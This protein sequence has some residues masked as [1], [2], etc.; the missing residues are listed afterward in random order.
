MNE[1]VTGRRYRHAWRSSCRPECGP[2]VGTQPR[3]LSPSSMGT[4]TSCP[5]A[6]RFSYIERL[7]EAAVGAR[8]QGHA[9][10]PGAAAPDV[11]AARRAHDRDRARRPR[12]GRAPSSR[13]TPSSRSS[14]S[15]TRSGPRSTP[16]PRCSCAATSRSRTRA[17]S[18]CSASSCA[19][20]AE[21]ADG[22]IDP[23]HH[24]PARARRRR[25]ARRHRLQDRQRAG[26]GLGT[27]EHGRRARLLAA[28]RAD[29]R[30][31]ARA[32]AAALPLE[33][34]SAS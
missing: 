21:T 2:H 18:R 13:P 25:R 26:R 31:P 29:V 3:S 16:T 33:A 14:S 32:R 7:P 28:V 8:Q 5:L 27:A 19:S 9:R 4:F 22:V 11:A 20:R 1:V 15:P 10:A 24:R 17:R 6:F 12:P 34:R 23:R 30:P